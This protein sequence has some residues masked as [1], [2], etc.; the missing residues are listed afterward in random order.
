MSLK[1][2]NTP[3]TQ[4]FAYQ[5]EGGDWL[6]TRERAGLLDVPGAGK[7]AQ[8]VRA[9]DLR[10]AQRGW[11]IVPAH[12]RENWIAELR[13]F[14]HF[15]RRV[16][17]GRS[18]HD[19]VAWSR[20]VFDV[21]VL[22]YEI[23]TKWAERLDEHCEI[24]DFVIIDEFHNLNN[25]HTKRARAIIGPDGDGVGG[26]VQ[27]ALQSWALTGTL[28]SND[29]SN[30]YAFLCFVRA[31]EMPFATFVR[32]FFT[33]RAST[34]GTRCRPKPAMV[35]ELQRLL[36]ENS[37]RR[38]LEQVGHQLPPIFL[39]TAIVEGDTAHVREMLAAHPGLDGA[40][41]A[42]VRQGGLSFLDSQH[43]ATLRRLIAEAK[44]LPYAEMLI[45]EL[46]ADPDQKVVVGGTS[47]NALRTI[48][49]AVAA[50]GIGAVI[51]QGGMS[52][53]AKDD[54]KTAFQGREASHPKGFLAHDPNCRV[55]ALNYEAGGTGLTAT[56]ATWV[57]IFESSWNPSK[58]DQ[59]VKRVRR[60]GQRHAQRA[61]F[62]G[63]ANSFDATVTQ[64][65][66]AKA[67]AIMMIDGEAMV[68][69]PPQEEVA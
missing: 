37:M 45:A 67:E 25:L 61:R 9:I 54:A 56:A 11:I 49:D 31:I 48:V 36:A 57:D 50:T 29:P 40:I 1:P 10:R 62:I 35:P 28:L 44:A 20:G 34:W 42:A 14:T 33:T 58:V 38:T 59:M 52:D 64:V 30:C 16:C 7:S 18:I 39:T 21:M 4:P 6:A 66:S 24:M 2:V 60:L 8:A 3:P 65:V 47:R 63:L 26:V 69:A 53:A 12:L 27:W 51:I 68:A 46:R 13:K 22:S 23:A 17:K 15:E 43:V 5:V 41:L 32:R 55:L 19:F